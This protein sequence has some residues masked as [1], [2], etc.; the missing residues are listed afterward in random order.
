MNTKHIR[1]TSGNIR[2]KSWKNQGNGKWKS[3]GLPVYGLGRVAPK[4]E[5]SALRTGSGPNSPSRLAPD[6][7]LIK[8]VDPNEVRIG[9]QKN[10]NKYAPIGAYLELQSTCGV[11]KTTFHNDFYSGSG[12]CSHSRHSMFWLYFSL[13]FIYHSFHIWPNW[14][15]TFCSEWNSFNGSN[16]STGMISK[17]KKSLETKNP[18]LRWIISCTFIANIIYNIIFSARAVGTSYSACAKVTVGG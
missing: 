14:F 9:R 6:P 8:R 18:C 16:I 12:A 15:S 1:E 11:C 10:Q 4:F 5:Q 3:G 7:D 13:L 2:G 17:K